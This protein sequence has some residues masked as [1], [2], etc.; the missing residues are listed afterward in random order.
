MTNTVEQN[1][2]TKGDVDSETDMD[3]S[4]F[5]LDEEYPE[6]TG[7]EAIGFHRPL[8]DEFWELTL[9]IITGIVD[10]FFLAFLTKLLYPF[11][12][13]KGYGSIAGG[14]F[15]LIYKIFDTGTNFGISRW[16][17]EYRVR[18]P[19]KMMEYIRF[20]IWYQ[21]FSGL[22]QVTIISIIIL[23]YFTSGAFAY[24]IWLMLIGLQKQ[25][26]SM[27]GIFKSCIG[28]LQHYDKSNILS[29]FQN[30]LIQLVCNIGFILIGRRYGEN[31]PELGMIMG[32]AIGSA[33]GGYIDDVILLFVSGYFFNKIVKP[34]GYSFK[35]AWRFKFGRDVVRNSVFYGIQSS[36]VPIIGSF[37]GTMTFFWY[38]DTI[39]ALATWRALSSIGMG[40]SGIV[41]S[42]GTFSLTSSIAESYCNGKRKLAEF[43]VSYSM[44]WKLFFSS[45][46]G[47]SVLAVIPFFSIFIEESGE[48][49]YWAPAIVFLVPGL[50]KRLINPFTGLPGSVFNGAL[51][52]TQYTIIRVVEEFM[53]LIFIWLW[54]YVV[55][56]QDLGIGGIIFL[57]TYEDIV[58]VIIKTAFCYIYIQRRIMKIR[59]Y[60]MTSVIIPVIA[61]LPIIAFSQAWLAWVYFPLIDALGL[62][63]ATV[64]SILIA[65]V[66]M[67][68]F[69]FF[70]LTAMLGGWDD[71]QVFTFE[72]A[73]NL[74]GPSRPL[75]KLVLRSIKLG[76]RI[77]RKLGLHGRFGIPYETAHQQ[78]R[79]LMELKR[80]HLFKKPEKG[81]VP[82]APWIK[83]IDLDGKDDNDSPGGA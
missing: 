82:N 7:W 23:Q 55:G 62:E 26:P 60:W 44:K 61:T 49:E 5:D 59:I 75:F 71:Y 73:C 34:M 57:I 58:P 76:V 9:E 41:D 50:M 51:Y 43:Y 67:L 46:L 69:V 24:V 56:I 18:D 27:L 31:H 48:L 21:M 19:E 83:K 38:V 1:V 22:I 81:P 42:V 3:S 2:T 33:I 17:A 4:L 25:W 11:P 40:F 6:F 53:K 70:P 65:Y 39:P 36:I 30:E 54:V 68:F 32:M 10:I 15:A 79:E 72:K 64:I 14:V 12:E 77:G 37:V 45:L 74:A 78:I 66:V 63:F 47:V 13:I 20:F 16:I 35:D 29:F 28:G 80:K 52:I 8:G